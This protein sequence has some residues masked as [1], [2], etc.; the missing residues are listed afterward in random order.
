MNGRRQQIQG[1]WGRILALLLCA[2]LLLSAAGCG[3]EPAES[4]TAGDPE[5]E[6]TGT[7][8]TGCYV[9]TKLTLPETSGYLWTLNQVAGVLYLQGS[10]GFWKSED[11]GKSWQAYELDSPMM[12]Q[13]ESEGFSLGNVIYGQDGTR[14]I[15][16]SKAVEDGDRF[17]SHTRYIIVD[18][19]GGERELEVRL[20][21]FELYAGFAMTEDTPPP[22]DPDAYATDLSRL[23]ILADGSLVGTT[24]SNIV[25]HLDQNTGEILHTIQPDRKSNDQWI[26]GL[27]FTPATMLVTT[28]TS[29]RLFDLETWEERLDT[30]AINEFILGDAEV[31][32]DGSILFPSG[33]ESRRYIELYSDGQEEAYYFVDSN[34]IY[35][36][37]P[38]GVSIEKLMEAPLTSLSLQNVSCREFVTTENHS[39]LALL[40]TRV[41]D[42]GQDTYSFVRYDY[43]EDAELEPAEELKIYSL[44]ETETLAQAIAVFQQEHKDILV[45]YHS[46]INADNI[47]AVTASDALRQLNTEIM[48]DKGPDII[49]MDGMPIENYQNKGL[50][51]DIT[52]VVEAEAAESE[53][54]RNVTDAYQ[55]DGKLFAVPAAFAMPIVVG[56]KAHLDKITGLESLADTVEE[57]RAGNKDV[58]SITGYRQY[59]WMLGCTAGIAGPGWVENGEANW[60]NI[61]RYYDILKRLYDAD[62]DTETQGLDYEDEDGVYHQ[63]SS[64]WQ[65]GDLGLCITYGESILELR[66]IQNLDGL[67]TLMAVMDEHP[68][69][70]YKPLE[71]NG[72]RSFTPQGIF[73][74]SAR[75]KHPEEAKAFVRK[76]LSKDIQS[77]NLSQ[78]AWSTLGMPV[79]FSVVR[80]KYENNLGKTFTQDRYRG[81]DLT[82]HPTA[83]RYPTAE[84]LEELLHMMKS[85]N[86]VDLS[87]DN[88]INAAICVN[89]SFYIYGETTKEEALETAREKLDLYLAES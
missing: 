55:K 8:A 75:S 38:G 54:L 5:P 63:Q 66:R 68:E 88:E 64:I 83:M 29:A 35:R 43:D 25:Y 57:L 42:Q 72:V 2:A 74:V 33:G 60:E 10:E 77:Y 56:D 70:I 89:C 32:E 26:M 7:V 3:Q 4:R 6:D 28:Q 36:Y 58:S 9:E 78:S 80:E 45:T 20:P 46:G 37:M 84:E 40:A 41:G 19:D 76:M 1:A 71:D 24:M 44:Y 86:T 27:A 17:Y 50:L 12:K 52:D 34:G 49:L 53:L 81:E 67:P 31:Q 11:Q 47:G 14:V 18:K 61:E 69:I 13:M 16:M 87:Q 15:T 30:D 85:L 23:R 48:A 51:L 22:E 65:E 73:G 59:G 79:N 62:N 39:F 82:P 21:A